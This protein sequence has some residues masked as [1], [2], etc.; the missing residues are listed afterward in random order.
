M[1]L[2]S[3]VSSLYIFFGFF[4]F[5]WVATF[6]SYCNKTFNHNRREKHCLKKIR[7]KKNKSIRFQSILCGTFNKKKEKF[8]ELFSIFM[9]IFKHKKKNLFTRRA[10]FKLRQKNEERKKF[11]IYIPRKSEKL[12]LNTGFSKQTIAVN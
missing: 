8:V 10:R 5:W 11:I 9:R 3:F 6:Y 4:F 12:T 1:L 2:R 7:R